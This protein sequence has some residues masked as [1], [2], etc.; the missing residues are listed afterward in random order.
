[1]SL[2]KGVVFKLLGKKFIFRWRKLKDRPFTF[3][4]GKLS[5]YSIKE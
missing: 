2:S 3:H 5:F 1:M 4:F